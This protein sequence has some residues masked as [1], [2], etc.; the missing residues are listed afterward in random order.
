MIKVGDKFR[1]GLGVWVVCE[2]EDDYIYAYDIDNTGII[3]EEAEDSDCT[4]L[5]MANEYSQGFTL[6][7][8]KRG[9]IK[10]VRPIT[11]YAK[12]AQTLLCDTVR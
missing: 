6:E 8:V 11:G 7:R 12:F 4:F 10:E 3:A 1:Y 2:L 5:E 9:L